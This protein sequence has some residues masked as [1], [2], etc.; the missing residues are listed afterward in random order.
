MSFNFMPEEVK[1]VEE[2]KEKKVELAEK[3]PSIKPGMVVRVYEKFTDLD[4]K[5]NPKERVQAFEGIV[6][7]CHKR[8][9]QGAT[10]TV[11]KIA[12]GG[13]G[14]E[15]IFPLYSPC[16]VKIEIVKQYKVRKAKLYYL[17]NYK[18]KLKEIK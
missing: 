7:S 8:K 10:I 11:R 3:I 12:S 1:K 9:E 2:K 4:A 14:V 6:L 18:K 13:I 5:G 17:R 16:I 15:K